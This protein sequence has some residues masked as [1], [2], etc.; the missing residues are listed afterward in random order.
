MGDLAQELQGMALLLEGVALRVAVA[1]DLEALR[2]DL[3]HLL[4]ARRLDHSAYDADA[5]PGGQGLHQMVVGQGLGPT[6][7]GGPL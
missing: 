7:P 6:P 1:Q 5:A 2:L 4:L 3:V